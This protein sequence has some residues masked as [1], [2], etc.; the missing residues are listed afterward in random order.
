[1]GSSSRA[2]TGTVALGNIMDF[3]AVNEH[4]YERV[5]RVIVGV[6]LIGFALYSESL[7]AWIGIVP[8]MT[9]V[10]GFCPIYRI[11]GFSTCKVKQKG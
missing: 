2:A 8:L 6:A 1:M 11:F 4:M 3:F 7:W 5:A 9:G 10:V